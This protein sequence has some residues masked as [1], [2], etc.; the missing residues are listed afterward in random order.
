MAQMVNNL[1]TMLETWFSPR[2]GKTPWRS[3]GNSLQCS[4]PENPQGQTSLEGYSPW[5]CK[6][7]HD[8]VTSI[9]FPCLPFMVLFFHFPWHLL[10][11]SRSDVSDSFG[12]SGLQSTRLPCPSPPPSRSWFKLMSVETVMPSNHI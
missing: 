3:T 7:W 4:C 2:V 11:F 8:W 12:P 6:V 10:L 5:G 9:H 1:L